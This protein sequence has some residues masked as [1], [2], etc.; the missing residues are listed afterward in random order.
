M[1]TKLDIEKQPTSIVH[2]TEIHFPNGNGYTPCSSEYFETDALLNELHDRYGT[3]CSESYSSDDYEA[4]NRFSIDFPRFKKPA[5]SA[6]ASAL[7]STATPAASN[8]AGGFFS[9]GHHEGS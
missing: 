6:R 9:G 1:K 5:I 2:D 8:S 4:A 3:V 7:P